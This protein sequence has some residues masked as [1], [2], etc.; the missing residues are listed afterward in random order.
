MSR[1]FGAV[2]AISFFVFACA[3]TSANI[4]KNDDG[5]FSVFAT[6]YTTS[7]AYRAALAAA[8][9]HCKKLGKRVDPSDNRDPAATSFE[10][11]KHPG[12][13]KPSEASRVTLEFRCI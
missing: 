13:A 3:P 1:V 11:D 6:S 5:T 7:R 10:K 2:F 8:Q 4:V 12:T 9:E